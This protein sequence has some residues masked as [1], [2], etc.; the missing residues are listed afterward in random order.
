MS[1]HTLQSNA[2]EQSSKITLFQAGPKI[3]FIEDHEFRDED[4]TYLARYKTT[5]VTVGGNYTDIFE[6][7]RKASRLWLK[8]EWRLKEEVL[9]HIKEYQSFDFDKQERVSYPIK[10]QVENV[11]EDGVNPIEA[12]N[13]TF[14][15]LDSVGKSKH[16]AWA[17]SGLVALGYLL[18]TKP[19]AAAVGVGPLF[20]LLCMQGC[21]EKKYDNL[22]IENSQ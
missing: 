11:P 3:T 12:H 14:K 20:S 21:Y 19:V 8:K 7:K 10:Y 17:I 1:S 2:Q 22:L 15:H 9:K 5:G 16:Y 18:G 13:N 6:K 4:E